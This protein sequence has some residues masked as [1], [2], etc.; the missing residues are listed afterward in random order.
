MAC[1][2]ALE[3]SAKYDLRWTDSWRHPKFTG[4][5]PIVLDR[6]RAFFGDAAEAQNGFGGWV[7]VRYR[8]IYDFA[9]KK[10]DKVSFEPGHY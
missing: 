6:F 5:G 2:K 8:C 1:Q 3:N 7:R 10:A 4:P 9:A